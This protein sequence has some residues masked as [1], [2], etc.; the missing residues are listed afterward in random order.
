[1][2]RGTVFQETRPADGF[3]TDDFVNEKLG[4]AT[5]ERLIHSSGGSG[6]GRT[7][8][9]CFCRGSR[10]L[11]RVTPLSVCGFLAS[12]LEPSHGRVAAS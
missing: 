9:A 4:G 7:L 2:A 8:G 5:V 12:V 1:M 11:A 10:P 6:R 3:K